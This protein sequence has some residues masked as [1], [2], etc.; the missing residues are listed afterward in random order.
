[1]KEIKKILIVVATE[2]ELGKIKDELLFNG[3][4]IKNN[5]TYIYKKLE[6]D[7]LI[8][9]I[10][11]PS[12]IY[13]LTKKLLQKKYSLVINIGICGSF[14]NNLQIGTC[15]NVISDEFADIGITDANN[16]F[17]TLF[18][19]GFIN[20]NNHPF[21]GGKLIS[22]NKYFTVKLKDVTAITVNN[23]SG[24]WEQIKMRRAKF[25]TDIETMEGAAVA[26]VCLL[27]DIY[28]VQIRSISNYVEPRN[29]ENWNIPLALSNLEKSTLNFLNSL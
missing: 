10:G 20:A 24:N 13:F 4:T 15:V 29:K 27:E 3:S 11:I 17:T 2:I 16:K 21:I 5:K 7:F 22:E 8:L 23:T 14:N 19:E 12:T 18:N 26:Y 9:G 6:I 1:M 28:F 25:N